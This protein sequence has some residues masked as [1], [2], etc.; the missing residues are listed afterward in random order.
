MLF[1]KLVELV[2]RNAMYAANARMVFVKDFVASCV[3]Q[4][5][6]HL[7]YLRADVDLSKLRHAYAHSGIST[8]THVFGVHAVDVTPFEDAANGEYLHRVSVP[9]RVTAEATAVYV[10]ILEGEM[11]DRSLASVRASYA[12]LNPLKDRPDASETV[13]LRPMRGRV[14][15]SGMLY[16]ASF[17]LFYSGWSPMREMIQEQTALTKSM[18]GLLK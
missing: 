15:P 10:M 9:V 4:R 14:V 1:T 2:E 17:R 11:S 13:T 3:I 18:E 7:L 12:S 6:G 16:R 5:R 8:F